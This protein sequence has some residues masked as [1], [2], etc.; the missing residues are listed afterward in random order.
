MTDDIRKE[1]RQHRRITPPPDFMVC[2]DETEV[3]E[4]YEMDLQKRRRQEPDSVKSKGE[5]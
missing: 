1:L 3:I 4:R 5:M 2:K